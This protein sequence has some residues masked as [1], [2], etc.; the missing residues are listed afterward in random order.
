VRR[1]SR[2]R[3]ALTTLAGLALAVSTGATIPASAGPKPPA[4][5]APA[6]SAPTVTAG[7]FS[8]GQLNWGPSCGSNQD[9]EPALR[10][11]SDGNVAVSSERG[12]GGGSDAWHGVA[13]G[14]SSASPCSLSY[15]GQPNAVSGLGASGGDTDIAIASSPVSPGGPD[16]IYVASLNVGSV[17][18]AHSDDGGKT[19]LNVPV[20]SGLPGDDR[21]WI[22]AY[23]SSTSLLTFHDIAT[24][25]INV[26]RS[27]NGGFAYTQIGEALNP[28]SQAGVNGLL[29][30]Q[31][32]NLAIDR[33][34]TSGTQALGP[35]PGFWA[36]QSYAAPSTDNTTTGNFNEAYVAVSSDGGFNWTDREVP[37]SKASPTLNLGN[38]FPNVSVDPSGKV[39]LTWSAGALDAAGNVSSA[40]V[41]AAVSSDHGATWSCSGAIGGGSS[42]AVMPW[43]AAA[44]TGADLVFYQ[45]SGG[46]KGTWSVAFVQNTT[47]SPTGWGTVQ[48]VTA[49][50]SG[51]VCELGF[52]CQGGRQLFDDFGVATD[53]SGW[54]HIAYSHDAPDLGGSGTYTGYAVQVS[55]ATVGQ[56]N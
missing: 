5:S 25:N 8:F 37:C 39:W 10:V 21:E 40:T 50:H 29:A 31:H 49:V 52:T 26:L 18:V 56:Q 22:A 9:G 24:N 51:A 1:P 44:S 27:D 11:G 35:L 32:G 20:Q 16:R 7:N 46:A 14:G 12:V 23:G 38:Q 41:Y 55:G 30:N 13:P 48:S 2:R 4:P 34:T 15:S 17:S 42:P 19:Y 45:A 3:V 28:S 33:V 53:S 6:S 47:G 43:I 54:A 36:Y